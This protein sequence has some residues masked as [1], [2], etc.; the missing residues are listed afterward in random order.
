MYYPNREPMKMIIKPMLFLFMITATCLSCN[1]EELFIEPT[2]DVIADTD[3]PVDPDTP[4]EDTNS[5]T[6]D[7]SL[8]CDFTLDALQ[9]GDTVIINCMMDLGGATINL[10]ANVTIVYEGG[11][12]INGTLNFSDNSVIS[13]ELLNSSLTLSG[14]SP[15]L[16]DTTFQF[17]PQRWGIVEGKVSDAVALNNGEIL[18]GMITQAKN[19]GISTFKIDEMDAYFGINNDDRKPYA[20]FVPS[21]FN[22]IMTDNTNLRIQPNGQPYYALLFSWEVDNVLISGGKLWGDRYTHDYNTTGGS[23]EYGHIIWFKAVQN[24]VVDNV[25]MHEGT[26]DGFYVSGSSDR[27]RDGSLK[28]DRRESFNITVKNCLIDDNRRNNIS[29]VDG[30]NIFIEYNTIR[31]AGSGDDSS[32]VSSN[33]TSPRAGI[34]IEARKHNF[35]DGNSVGDIE[36]TENVH[37]RHNIME[38]NYAGDVALFNGENTFVYENTFRS[39]GGVGSAYSYNNKIYNNVFER[40]E[41]LMSGSAA[42]KLEPR[43]WANGNHRNTDFEVY[44]NTISGYQ[45]AILAGGQGNTFNNNT[46]TD[47]QRGIILLTSEDLVFDNNTISSNISNSYG[48]YTFSGEGSIK[49]CLINNGEISVQSR[50]LFFSNTNND[51]AG[52]ITIDNVDFNGGG[53]FLNSAQNITIKNSTFDDIKIIDCNPILVNNN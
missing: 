43:Y 37:I 12:I 22:L 23:H 29:I 11:D 30:T 50:D 6:V 46:M 41:G 42:I 15:L 34:D 7:T 45:F 47:C 10:P 26:G 25:E 52:Y 35:P 4:A 31:N 20:I 17:D 9:A 1:N 5:G 18:N 38:D 33:G 40:P 51:E 48:Y 28:E 27:N 13:G 32:E 3:T 2:A 8:P 49:N 36:K 14:S 39:K 44:G 21:N 53:I 24:G 19:M 16:K